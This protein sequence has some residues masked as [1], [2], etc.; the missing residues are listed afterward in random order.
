M[1][2]ERLLSVDSL[3]AVY[4]KGKCFTI[5]D[6]GNNDLYASAETRLLS[7]RPEHLLLDSL[8]SL[9]RKERTKQMT[10]KYNFFFY[11][12]SIWLHVS[13]SRVRH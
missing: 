10:I 11:E 5:K 9:F 1:Q 3:Q 2:F 8:L 12:I 13:I 6:T 4:R 7:R